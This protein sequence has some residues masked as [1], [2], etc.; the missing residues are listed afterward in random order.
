MNMKIWTPCTQFHCLQLD[1]AG[2]Q[3][4]TY[5]ALIMGPE[6]NSSLSNSKE[7]QT[8]SDLSNQK[9]ERVLWLV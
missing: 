7:V 8:C 9:D 2:V 4:S 5:V 3:G 6:S 1:N